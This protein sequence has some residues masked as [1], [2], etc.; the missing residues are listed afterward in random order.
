MCSSAGASPLRWGP[1]AP[2]EVDRICQLLGG[3]GRPLP[4]GLHVR[5]G[6]NAGGIEFFATVKD[7]AAVFG[8][9]AGED[10]GDLESLLFK[11]CE[12][13][14]FA[15]EPALAAVDPSLFTDAPRDD[16]DGQV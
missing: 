14:G 9:E 16:D 2:A 3:A 12:W 7:G 1:V 13:S 10:F 11:V 4:P 15:V 6:C 5:V 8:P